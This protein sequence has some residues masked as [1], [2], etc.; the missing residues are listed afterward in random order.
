MNLRI[1]G[2]AIVLAVAVASWMLT[3]AAWRF[4]EV[5]AGVIPL[6]ARDFAR[7]TV[8]TLGTAG[9]AANQNRRGPCTA[10]ALDGTVVL[11]DAGRGV[12]ESLRAA[13]IPASQP[14]VVLLTNLLPENVV[15]LDDL[16]A[17]AWRLGRRDPIRVIGPDGTREVALAA[18][19]DV[20]DGAVARARALGD[21]PA[22]PAFD[23]VEVQ[24]GFADRDGGI[25]FRAAGLP[26]GPLPALAWR[27][28]A[29]GRSVVVSGTGWGAD[30]LVQ[31]ASGADVLVHDAAFVPTPE[32]AAQLGVEEDPARLRREAGLHTG[33]DEAGS[34]AQ[35]AGVDTLVLVRLRP[36]PVFDLQVTSV[37]DDAFD[38]RIVVAD[39]GEEIAP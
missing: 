37:V 34:I 18:A 26:G 38:G 23:A 8:V 25:D 19:R 36:P 10:V 5:R 29:Q 15:G 30:A 27:L 22:P 9:A 28:E 32:Q 1:V 4:D 12:A 17:A 13:R 6:E 16:V 35:R 11:V 21:D 2:F 31:A 39:D 3:C 20:A 14:D 7:P 33:L 24:D